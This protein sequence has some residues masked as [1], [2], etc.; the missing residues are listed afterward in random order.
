[1][2]ETNRAIFL[3]SETSGP[4]VSTYT[5]DSADLVILSRQIL[6]DSESV[7]ERVLILECA[8][9]DTSTP[10]I[11]ISISLLIGGQWTD[12][13]SIASAVA[14]PKQFVVQSYDTS[15]WKKNNGVQFQITKAGSGDVTHI[16]YWI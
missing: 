14:V 8:D 13:E 1:M 4:I 3:Q 7:K 2:A 12:F 16:G 11:Q 6:E 5:Q 15:W 9:D 10:T